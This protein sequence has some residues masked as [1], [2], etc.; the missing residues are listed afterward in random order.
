MSWVDDTV[1]LSKRPGGR[2]TS[3]AK[4]VNEAKRTGAAVET[5]AKY[6]AGGN[7][8]HAQMDAAKL[9]RETEELKHKRLDANVGKLIAQGRAAKGWSQKDLA[10]RICEKPVVIQEM[11]QGKAIPNQQI[12]GKIERNI[13]I[14]LRGKNIGDPLSQGGKKK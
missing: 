7:H 13:G 8:A 12:L 3:N 5:T 1:T 14:K 9:D 6:G 4:A 11:E 10:T 2:G